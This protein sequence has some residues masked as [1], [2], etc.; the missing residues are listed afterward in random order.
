MSVQSAQVV[1]KLFTLRDDSGAV[2]ADSLPA[3]TLVI[4]GASDAASVTVTNLDTGLY[5]WSVTLPTLAVS[6]N[7]EIVIQATVDGITEYGL[8]WDD[9]K[10]IDS[11]I[12]ESGTA[13]NGGDA[14]SIV[15]RAGASG[16]DGIF[17]NCLL[18]IYSGTG[19]GQ[20]RIVTGYDGTSKTASV[21]PDLLINNDDTSLYKILASQQPWVDAFGQIL[22]VSAV[23]SCGTV[24]TVSNPVTLS[25]SQPDVTFDSLSIANDF[26]I[27]ENINVYGG[28]GV[29]K[30]VVIIAEGSSNNPAVSLTGD[31]TGPGLAVQGGANAD[32]IRSRSGVSSGYGICFAGAQGGGRMRGTTGDAVGLRLQSTGSGDGLEITGSGSG[33]GIN[34]QGGANAAAVRLYGG[35]SSG[36]A[37]EMHTTNGPGV[38]IEADSGNGIEIYASQNAIDV[39]ANGNAVY[40]QSS[41]DD[42]VA[43]Y[44]GA[45]SIGVNI[46]GGYTSGEAVKLSTQGSGGGVTIAGPVNLPAYDAEPDGPGTTFMD[47]LCWLIQWFRCG[48]KSASEIL[49]KKSDAT[50]VIST[51][52]ITSVGSDETL[53]PPA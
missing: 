21:V 31:G 1:T 19:A 17:V 34:V 36:C 41:S 25:T 33:P 35:S 16:T 7:V 51:Q 43:I 32:G 27:D 53:G 50:T 5:S 8:V 38:F 11:L 28:I 30:G 37:V 3:G 52:E 18:A 39:Y 13:Q 48:S 46:W 42:A 47:K 9:S 26:N 29:N 12:I 44:P 24:A 10:E 6:D 45:N 40:L 20:V 14:G 4:N 49:V 22:N 23:G 2:D 15:L